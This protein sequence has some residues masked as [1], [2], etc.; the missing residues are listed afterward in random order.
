MQ[1]VERRV[2]ASV[3]VCRG[4]VFA[5]F[6][7]AG[8]ACVLIHAEWQQQSD[9][10]MLWRCGVD[11]QQQPN[12]PDAA[13][14]CSQ[15]CC[16]W[17][18][19]PHVRAD[20]SLEARNTHPPQHPPTLTPPAAAA[21][22]NKSSSAR[23]SHVAAVWTRPTP[24]RNEDWIKPS[25]VPK[26]QQQPMIQ[27]RE[28]PRPLYSPSAPEFRPAEMPDK[29]GEMPEGPKMPGEGLSCVWL[30]GRAE[31][32]VWVGG[33]ESMQHACSAESMQRSTRAMQV[34]NPPAHNRHAT[35]SHA[36]AQRR[37]A[38]RPHPRRQPQGEA[39]RGRQG[40]GATRGPAGALA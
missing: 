39:L 25:Y 13:L 17:L 4:L 9:P 29:Q 22:T 3:S 7:H 26:P 23:A 2:D 21:T 12:R 37:A 19:P 18:P 10:L 8:H 27:P 36:T 6:I 14:R 35:N 15:R 31:L 38:A 40:G 11:V 1:W 16:A 28:E 30:K 32:W 5:W 20:P 33:A 34:A 24:D